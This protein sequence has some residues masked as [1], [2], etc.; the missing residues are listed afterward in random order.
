MNWTVF[1]VS[2]ALIYSSFGTVEL[3]YS[4]P[5]KTR[6]KFKSCFLNILNF[7]GVLYE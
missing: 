4:T 5:S 2:Q 1:L 3:A 6:T 7:S